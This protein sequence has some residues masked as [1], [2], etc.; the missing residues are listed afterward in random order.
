MVTPTRALQA[1]QCWPMG[2]GAKCPQATRCT[3]VSGVADSGQV[4]GLC[5]TNNHNNQSLS[6]NSRGRKYLVRN[7]WRIMSLSVPTRDVKWGQ[8]ILYYPSGKY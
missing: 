5:T 8:G 4:W 6:D 7:Q 1:G 2:W 3:R